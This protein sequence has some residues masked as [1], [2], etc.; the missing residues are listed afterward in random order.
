MN[1]SSSIAFRGTALNTSEGHRQFG[2][3]DY[4]PRGKRDEG[5]EWGTRLSLSLMALP[6]AIYGL[7]YD[8]T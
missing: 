3:G 7:G 5:N 4:G 1:M 8:H 6:P 2:K